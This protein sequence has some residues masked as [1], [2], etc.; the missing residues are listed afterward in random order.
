MKEGNEEC[1]DGN[2]KEGDGCGR[3]CRVE[4]P[5]T[6]PGAAIHLNTGEMVT[7]K[8]TTTGIANK[9]AG[10]RTGAPGNCNGNGWAVADLVYAVTPNANGTLKAS[11][12]TTYDNP[13]LHVRTACANSSTADEISCQ[14]SWQVGTIALPDLQVTAG[15]TYYI[16]AGST[17]SN[18]A[19]TLNLTLQ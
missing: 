10:T 18:G 15:A 6:C 14:F 11:L 16:A 9:F 19:F 1:D 8:G 7:I 13:L 2:V 4:H 3:D 12:T 17:Y 5:E